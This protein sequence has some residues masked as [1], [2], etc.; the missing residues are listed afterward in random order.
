MKIIVI[1]GAGLIGSKVVQ[2]LTQQGHQAVAA[3]PSSGVNSYTGEG[4]DE[5]LAGAQV[6]VDLANSPSFEDAAVLDFFRTAGGNLLKAEANAGVGHHVALTIVGA[7]RVPDSGYMRA[8]IAQEQVIKDGGVPYTI[9]RATQFMEFMRAIADSATDGSTV[10]VPA[11]R[12]QPIAAS[13][14]AAEVTRAA[15]S[16]PVNGFFEIAGP[17]RIAFPDLMR[18]VLEADHDPRTVQADEH[19]RYFG[20]ELTDDSITAG[21][22]ARLGTVTFAQ[23][24]ATDGR[25]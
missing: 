16:Q 20:T 23:W 24:L 10:R 15:I 5:V 14:V 21:P 12:L 19:A 18:G 8:K 25:K 13:D 2:N 7:D 11:A 6:V 1:G 3:S 22:D 4:L 17:E 9:V